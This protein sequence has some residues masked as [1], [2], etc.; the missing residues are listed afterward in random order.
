MGNP[1][2]IHVNNSDLIIFLFYTHTHNLSWRFLASGSGDT[3]VR[4]WDVTTE[5]PLYTCS[6]HKH[7]ILFISW[8]PDGRKLASGCK[9]GQVRE[10]G[11]KE[12]EEEGGREWG[13]QEKYNWNFLSKKLLWENN[14]TKSFLNWSMHDYLNFVGKFFRLPTSVMFV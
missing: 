11:E 9:N 2:S 10:R 3:T 12:R 8:S 1:N 13:N 4:F 6:A 7:W 5:T 14:F